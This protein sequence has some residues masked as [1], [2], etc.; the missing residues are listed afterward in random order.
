MIHIG[1]IIKDLKEKKYVKI[2]ILDGRRV[3]WTAV[4]KYHR[5][6]DF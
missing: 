1:H 3:E 4:S 6:V 5:I 2:K